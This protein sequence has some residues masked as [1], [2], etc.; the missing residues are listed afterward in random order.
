M[1]TLS[2]VV[3]IVVQTINGISLNAFGI[4]VIIALAIT[5]LIVTALTVV[6]PVIIYW[7]FTRK[8]MPG[9]NA[10]T[11]IVWGFIAFVLVYGNY[12]NRMRNVVSAGLPTEADDVL[13]QIANMTAKE[14]PKRIDKGTV[15]AGVSYSPQL[16]TLTYHMAVDHKAMLSIYEETHGV[17]L[18]DMELEHELQE[19]MHRLS[20]E[21]GCNGLK[22]LDEAFE[23]Q[24][25][26]SISTNLKIKYLYRLNGKIYD[27]IVTVETCNS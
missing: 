13:T 8:T 17:R 16:D 12:Y 18:N 4:S 20:M 15:M 9:I 3:S 23:K 6:I 1:V 25:I 5:I 2:V 14:L 10:M 21:Y 26:T 7:L 19:I 22:K 27:Y 24:R 11:W